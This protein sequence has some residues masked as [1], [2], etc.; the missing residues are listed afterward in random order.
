M[1]D[2]QH[3]IDAFEKSCSRGV[4]DGEHLLAGAFGVGGPSHRGGDVIDDGGH[5]IPRMRS[6]QK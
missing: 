1:G 5:G 2:V 4:A 3:L 6:L